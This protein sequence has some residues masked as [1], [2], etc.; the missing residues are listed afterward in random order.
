NVLPYF[1]DELLDIGCGKMPYKKYLLEHSKVNNYVGL[2][3]ETALEY[4]TVV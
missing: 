2:D 1:K 3:I 4:D